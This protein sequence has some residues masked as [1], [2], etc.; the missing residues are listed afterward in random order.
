MLF[1][2]QQT[3]SSVN[4]RQQTRSSVNPRQQTRSSVNP[5]QQ[6]K[7]QSGKKFLE[8]HKRRHKSDKVETSTNNS[9][10]ES[11][12]N[13]KKQEVQ[14]MR[15]ELQTRQKQIQARQKQIQARQ[16]QLQNKK[17]QLERQKNAPSDP[18]EDFICPITHDVMENPVMSNRG[19]SFE[20]DA[21]LQWLER[22]NRCPVSRQ[23]LRRSDLRPNIA[24]KN[25]IE[26]WNTKQMQKASRRESL[27]RRESQS[28][29][30]RQSQ[31]SSRNLTIP[32][33]Q[34]NLR[35]A[36]STNSEQQTS[37]LFGRFRRYFL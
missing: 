5:R 23:P 32:P 11:Q 33:E 22:S 14:K 7:S 18:P 16:K 30:R 25:L 27:S 10:S 6:T 36:Q 9:S 19:I 37:G 17:Q 15:K 21:I 20:E 12:L 1:R 34:V 3:R 26:L 13:I 4:P 28:S 35:R 29:S 31:Q 2:S 8:A 24:L